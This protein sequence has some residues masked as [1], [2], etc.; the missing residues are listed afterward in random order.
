MVWGG[1]LRILPVVA[2]V[3]L[4][5]TAAPGAD[6]DHPFPIV[7]RV[8]GYVGDKP[9]GVKSLARWV[10][11]VGGAQYTI[12]VTKLEPIG[13]D[14]AYWTI[15]N[16]LEPLPVKMTV[17][18]DAELLRRFTGAPPAVP[19]V[20]TGSF[21]LGPGPATLLLSSVEPQTDA[22]PVVAAPTPR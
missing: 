5:G 13:V 10:V 15:L 21:E 14:I 9:E 12:H 18:G 6:L 11:A 1:A 20:I 16:R 8:T 17:Y 7:L 2:V 19:M 3:G 4:L 22:T